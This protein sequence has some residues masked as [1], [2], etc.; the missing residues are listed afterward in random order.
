MEDPNNGVTAE[1][2][3]NLCLL[4]ESTSI[5]IRFRQGKEDKGDEASGLFVI[6]CTSQQRMRKLKYR[7]KS[8]VNKKNAE[9]WDCHNKGHFE[10][11]CPMSKSKEKA[12]ALSV[13]QLSLAPNE[14]CEVSTSIEETAKD[15]WERLEGLYQDRCFEGEKDDE[16]SGLFVIG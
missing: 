14:L 12:N 9:C 10:R 2:R 13:I 11:D 1:E 3:F 15:L 6:G 8:R 4:K 16:A 5:D 7:S